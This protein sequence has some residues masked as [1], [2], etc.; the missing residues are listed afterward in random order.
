M[1]DDY[2]HTPK[3]KFYLSI[4][5]VILATISAYTTALGMASI[6]INLQTFQRYAVSGGFAVSISLLMVFIIMN[7]IGRQDKKFLYMMLITY[8]SVASISLFFNFNSIYGFM[9]K[10]SRASHELRLVITYTE[11][12][13]A[14]AIAA[15]EKLHSVDT[16]LE[17]LNKKRSEMETEEKHYRRPGRGPIYHE[18]KSQY[19]L[20][21]ARLSTARLLVEKDSAVFKKEYANVL[22]NADILQD[23]SSYERIKKAI[24]ASVIS[25]DIMY[26]KY[27]S[28]F[29][30]KRTYRVENIKKYIDG[31]ESTASSLETLNEVLFEYD[32]M[33]KWRRNAVIL[34]L[35]I[36][37]ILD[38]PIFLVVFV[39]NYRSANK[40]NATRLYTISSKDNNDFINF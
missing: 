20:L 8:L 21:N 17:D 18:L 25:Y 14:N 28:L 30:H 35:F 26:H 24:E 15:V 22:A 10:S 6:F 2:Q 29:G 7:L 1:V 11:E 16:L 31:G 27:S 32:T 5:V 13:Y 23:G 37:F 19:N 4:P 33:D 40:A 38:F 39:I 12:L 34:S 36:G 9:T 3:L